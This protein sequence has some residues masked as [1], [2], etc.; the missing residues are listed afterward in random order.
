LVLKDGQVLLGRRKGTHGAGEYATPG[1][2]LEFG[3]SLEQCA[4]REVR[5]ETGL[6]VD[7]VR[8]LRL[9]NVKTYAG[10]HYVDVGLVANWK[11][12]QPQLLEPDRCEG[13]GWYSLEQLPAPLF[14]TEPSKIEAYRTGRCYFDA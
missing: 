14:A 6:E 10:T 2:H 9:L 12:G 5:E 4:R 1:G 3:E 11:R 7:D 8:F 13:W